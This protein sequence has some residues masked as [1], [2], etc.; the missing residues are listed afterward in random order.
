MSKSEVSRLCMTLD[1][2]VEAFRRRKLDKEYP[3]LWL[4]AVYLKVRDGKH[5]EQGDA[6]GVRS[7]RVWRAGRWWVWRLRTERWKSMSA[8]SWSEQAMARLLRGVHLVISDAPHGAA[9]GDSRGAQ[10]GGVALYG[11]LSEDVL[12]RVP[13]AAQGYVRRRSRRFLRS[14][15]RSWRMRRCTKPCSC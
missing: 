13:K 11:A 8:A 5:G 12:S 4:D 14:R 1:E 6:G 10:W 15:R 7:E 9:S 2:E 3:Y